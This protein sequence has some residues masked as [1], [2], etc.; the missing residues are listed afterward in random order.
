MPLIYP[1]HNFEQ[2]RSCAGSEQS[3]YFSFPYVFAPHMIRVIAV[4]HS[5]EATRQL[6]WS[7]QHLPS[8]YITPVPFLHEAT[9]V[10]VNL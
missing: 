7:V 6:R 3:S 8:I 4:S 1:E 2:A 10:T 9:Q 5:R